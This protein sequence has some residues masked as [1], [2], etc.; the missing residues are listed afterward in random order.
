MILF[1]KIIK[2]ETGKTIGKMIETDRDPFRNYD[3]DRDRDLLF[4]DQLLS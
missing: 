3:L 1:V 2:L 4:R